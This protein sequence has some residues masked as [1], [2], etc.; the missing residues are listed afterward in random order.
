MKYVNQTGG[1][2]E[3]SMELIFVL[4]NPTSLEQIVSF[5]TTI[6]SSV[7]TLPVINERCHILGKRGISLS[8]DLTSWRNVD[9]S[10]RETGASQMETM[11]SQRVVGFFFWKE[12]ISYFEVI[13]YIAIFV[14]KNYYL[15][16]LCLDRHFVSL[17][18]GPL[19]KGGL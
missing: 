3:K 1:R 13:L 5:E 4:L 6:Y 15:K 7:F 10:H 2:C 18:A 11:S 14:T 12:V 17:L 9:I 8:E 16:L 19:K